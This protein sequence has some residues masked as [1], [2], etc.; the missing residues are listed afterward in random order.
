MR[1]M[2]DHN[3]I[4]AV[5]EIK[6]ID[7]TPCWTRETTDENNPTSLI[8][9]FYGVDWTPED[10]VHKFSGE[11]NLD[12]TPETYEKARKNWNSICY[13]LLEKGYCKASDFENFTWY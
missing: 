5:E 4:L 8:V 10:D 7:A 3:D 12:G 9:T 11:Y 1:F 2:Y 6:N 13:Q